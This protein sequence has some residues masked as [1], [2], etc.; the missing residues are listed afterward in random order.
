M[1]QPYKVLRIEQ[2]RRDAILQPNGVIWLLLV[3]VCD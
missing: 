1:V 2:L 3:S